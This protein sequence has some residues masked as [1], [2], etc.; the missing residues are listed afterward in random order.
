MTWIGRHRRRLL[1]GALL[2]AL[3]LGAAWY[4]DRSVP[5]FLSYWVIDDRS[6]GVQAMDGRNATCWLAS[7]AETTAEVR[8]DVECNPQVLIGSSTAEGY[9]YDFTVPLLAPLGD[10][11]VVDALGTESVVCT[12]PRCGMP[13]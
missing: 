13:G 1:G 5:K 4:V 9:P 8:V 6:I 2:L 10:R 3:A 7:V 11:R 12:A